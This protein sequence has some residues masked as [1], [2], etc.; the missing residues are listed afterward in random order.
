M[1]VTVA[2]APRRPLRVGRLVLWA[3]VTL[4][5]AQAILPYLW[6]LVS[7]IKPEREI[8]SPTS[9]LLPSAPTLDNFGY[10]LRSTPLPRYFLNSLIVASSTVLLSL[11]I[12]ISAG[13][14]FSR[15]RF[16]GRSLLMALLL[17]IY[18]FPAALLVVPLFAMV[19]AA[20]LLDTYWGLI[21]AYTTN[22][23]PFCVWMLTGYFDAIPRDLEEA[24]QVDGATP[25]HAFLRIVVPLALPGVVATGMFSFIFSWN[26]YLYAL[27]F[28][29]GEAVRTL[30]VGL[31]VFLT[32]EL[33]V[34]WGVI[35]AQAVIT[36]MPIVL[37]FMLFQQ[38]LVRG[39]TAG[40]IK[41]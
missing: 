24:A 37:V 38:H 36:T 7:S 3:G 12:S 2:T 25:L 8:L 34:Q 20:G 26:E 19:R 22:T 13:Y 41:G 4:V 28:T 9:G 27:F 39:L 40:A 30:P 10:V 14:A 35:N 23:V 31:Q 29:T 17:L 16:R 21:L 15:F 11:A 6:V 5:L 33:S 18:M 32:G 1:A